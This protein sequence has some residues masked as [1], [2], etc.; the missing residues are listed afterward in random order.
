MNT[1][2][3][4]VFGGCNMELLNN[5]EFMRMLN[6]TV[7]TES[8]PPPKELADWLHTDWTDAKMIPSGIR[9]IMKDQ[10]ETP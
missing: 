1:L 4:K 10:N 3:N 6:G 8:D 9:D 7:Y 5:P 2:F